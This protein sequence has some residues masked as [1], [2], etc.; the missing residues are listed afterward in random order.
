[1]CHVK[2]YPSFNSPTEP[3]YLISQSLVKYKAYLDSTQTALVN[4][5]VGFFFTTTEQVHWPAIFV[6][7]NKSAR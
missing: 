5:E 3:L 4:K 6:L 7:I 1:M 2:S